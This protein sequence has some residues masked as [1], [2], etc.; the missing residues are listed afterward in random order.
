M[1]VGHVNSQLSVESETI[2]TIVISRTEP[3]LAVCRI[4]TSRSDII[5]CVRVS[6]TSPDNLSA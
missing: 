3:V 6:V 5:V 1:A 4:T 2:V